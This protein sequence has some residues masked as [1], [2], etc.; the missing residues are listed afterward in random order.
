MREDDEAID[1][2]L[3]GYTAAGRGEGFEL[4]AAYLHDL[5]AP[6]DNAR[7]QVDAGDDAVREA[8]GVVG[9][10]CRGV[11]SRS[12]GDL[13][14]RYRA[15]PLPCRRGGSLVIVRECELL[16]CTHGPTIGYRPIHR[17]VSR[18]RRQL[19]REG[20]GRQSP[21]SCKGEGARGSAG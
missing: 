18:S 9:A 11:R 15:P 21:L 19:T 14:P 3:K 20:R 10:L 4:R 5:T 7:H 1:L 12:V 8:I 6:K 13:T 17:R 16:A 2:Q